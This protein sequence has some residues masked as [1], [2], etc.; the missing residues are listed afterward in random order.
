[1]SGA[2]TAGTK[3][4]KPIT[5]RDLARL[6]GVSQSAVSRAFTPGSSI[7]PELRQ[8]IL[9][10]SQELDYQPNAIASML[11]TRRSN[12]AGIVVSELHNP[13]YPTLIEK[14]SRSLQQAGLQSLMF[15]ITRGSNVEEQL[16]ALRKYN[17]DAVVV[18]S[19]T[20][21]SGP[22]LR[23]ATEGRA[24]VLVNR[25]IPEGGIT[26]VTCNNVEGARTI[27]NHFHEIGRHRVAYIG[28]LPHTSTNTERQ[29]AFIQRIAELGM[30][31]THSM[32]AGEY[33]FEAGYHGALEL[34]A[35]NR[36]DAIFFA[37]DI[38]AMGGMEALR[39][40]AGLRIPEDIAVAGFDDISMGHWPRFSLTTYSQPVDQ[41]VATTVDQITRQLAN[42]DHPVTTTQLSGELF[43]RH[44]TVAETPPEKVP[45]THPQA[46]KTVS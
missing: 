36:P 30:V 41:L 39:E 17:V 8:R 1:M 2:E 11:S 10:A 24:A 22:S 44:S 9:R 46:T 33:S 12:I 7:S 34:I 35:K 25:A 15:N 28:G 20:V 42:P 5:A 31:L 40:V 27:A 38:L 37:N 19:A 13:F 4:T 43:V 18:I 21:V 29:G 3:R 45:R 26:T 14:L 23:W 6:M 32:S 16:V